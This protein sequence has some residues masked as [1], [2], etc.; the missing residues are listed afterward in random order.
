MVKNVSALLLLQTKWVLW[1][2][3]LIL[4]F[5]TSMYRNYRGWISG[6]LA[7]VHQWLARNVEGPC[8]MVNG[9]DNIMRPL[10]LQERSFYGAVQGLLAFF[11][12]GVLSLSTIA[13]L[14]PSYPG[15]GCPGHCEMFNNIPGLCALHANTHSWLWQSKMSSNVVKWPLE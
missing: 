13:I 3:V 14:D 10:F 9:C 6:P 8:Y 4:E 12:V 5:Y 11:R 15:P 2:C 7:G 1:K